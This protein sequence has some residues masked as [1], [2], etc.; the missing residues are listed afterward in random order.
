MTSKSTLP[1][2]K[3]TS[4]FQASGSKSKK[5]GSLSMTCQ[6]PRAIGR[7][8]EVMTK[9]RYKSLYRYE[10]LWFFQGPSQNIGSPEWLSAFQ[11]HILPVSCGGFTTKSNENKPLR[12]Y[13]KIVAPMNCEYFSD[14]GNYMDF[15]KHFFLLKI[16]L[17]CIFLLPRKCIF[18]VEKVKDT[19]KSIKKWSIN[20]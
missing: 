6:P 1:Y 12:S 3:V 15:L 16:T 18:I 20:Q 4:P 2:D 14:T 8:S 9:I 7:S 17:C 11:A 13:D 10:N 19:D 5:W